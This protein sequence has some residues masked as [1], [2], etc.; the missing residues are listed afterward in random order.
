MRGH[1]HLLWQVELDVDLIISEG[2]SIYFRFTSLPTCWSRWTKPIHH[3][4][5]NQRHLKTVYLAQKTE[6]LREGDLW[7]LCC[8]QGSQSHLVCEGFRSSNNHSG[9]EWVSSIRLWNQQSTQ[10]MS[11]HEFVFNGNW[12]TNQKDIFKL[13]VYKYNFEQNTLM[14]SVFMQLNYSNRFYY[15]SCF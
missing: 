6:S 12:R 10:I 8:F 11:E 13:M 7:S 2:K 9:I 4:T 5:L 14:H 3:N 1:S 15:W